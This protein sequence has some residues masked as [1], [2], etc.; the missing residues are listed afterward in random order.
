MQLKLSFQ[1][2]ATTVSDGGKRINQACLSLL[3]LLPYKVVFLLLWREK[4]KRKGIVVAAFF[5]PLITK[6]QKKGGKT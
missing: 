3:S 5:S 1:Y 4:K 2:F 6:R